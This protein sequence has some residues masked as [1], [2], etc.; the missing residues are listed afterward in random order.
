MC[1]LY[2]LTIRDLGPGTVTGE[3][4][5]ITTKSGSFDWPG[6][7]ASVR[8]Y[9]YDEKGDL[10]GKDT[11]LKAEVGKPLPLTVPKDGMV[12]AEIIP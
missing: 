12:I 5:L 6:R 3:E 4:R 1:K 2:P 11:V 10:T 9:V 8:L 7:A